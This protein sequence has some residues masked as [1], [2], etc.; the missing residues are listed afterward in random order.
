[1]FTCLQLCTN[2][3]LIVQLVE[4]PNK[5]PSLLSIHNDHY[6]GT[7]HIKLHTGHTIQ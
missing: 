5:L 6:I 2:G 4:T 1:M 3:Y 7:T